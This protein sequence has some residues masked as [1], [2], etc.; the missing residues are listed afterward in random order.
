MKRVLNWKGERKKQGFANKNSV[1]GKK[2]KFVKRTN[3][4]GV[5]IRSL[6][7]TK[8]WDKKKLTGDFRSAYILLAP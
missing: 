7:K 1:R 4:P 5:E 3:L 8:G 2:K 6:E